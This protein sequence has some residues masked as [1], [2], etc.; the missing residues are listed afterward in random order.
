MAYGENSQ[1]SN[2]EFTQ[3]MAVIIGIN[4]YENGIPPLGTAQQDA[5]AIAEI[6]KQDYHYQTHSIINNQ[7][8]KQQLE[9]LLNIDLPNLIN[10]PSS[11]LIFY[12][13]GHGI[14]LNGDEGPQGYLIP[15]DGKLGDVSTYLPMQ[16][17]ETA[18][19]KL[20]CRHCFV[21]LD[22]CF[23]GAFRWSSTRR[24]IH[25]PKTIHKERYDRFIQDS[26]WQVIT[27]AGYDQT[28]LDNLDLKNDR[29]TA[30]NQVNHSP[31]A[32]ALMEALQGKADVYPPSQN[33][34][35]AGDGIITATELYLYLRDFVEVPTYALKQR[36]TPQIWSLSKHD[37][38]EF[39]FLVP[40]HPLNLPSAP[41]LDDI[42]ENNP[43]RGLKSYEKKHSNLFFGRTSLIKELYEFISHPQHPLTVVLGASGSGKSSLVKA[44]L[45][46][47]LDPLHQWKTLT[48]IRP[49]ETPL[50]RLNGLIKELDYNS[51]TLHQGITNWSKN[52][53]NQKL[54][55]VIDQLEELITL[56]RDEKEKEQFLQILAN[57]VTTYDDHL[58]IVVTLRSDFES[59][60]SS[61][62]LQEYWQE[63]RFIVPAMSRNDL[64][65]VIEEPASAKVVYFQSLEDK[66]YLVDRLIDEVAD[67]PG[68][69]PLLS[70][71][72]SE[73]Y[74]KLASRY[75]EGEKT[76]ET[77]DR[78]ITWQDYDELG[79]VI[80]SLTRRA[81]EEYNAL[82]KEDAAY[83]T[84]IR[85]VMLRMVAIGGEL[86]RRRVYQKELVYPE[87]EYGRV[88][89]FIKRF[90][91]VRL[92][93]SDQDERGEY[94]EPAHDALVTGWEKL[95]TWK[96][97]EEET[98]ILQRRLTPTAMEWDSQQKPVFLWH[99][100]P[101][102]DLLKKVANSDDNWL[103][104]VETEF[105]RRSV[106][107]KTFNTRRNWTVAITVML[108]LSAGLIFSLIGYRNTLIEG[109]IASQ[110]SAQANLRFNQSLDG[111]VDGLRAAK[112]IKHPLVQTPLLEQFNSTQTKRLQALQ[113]QITQTL[114]WAVYRVKET[115]RLTGHSSLIVRSIVS[116]HS[117]SSDEQFIASAGEDGHI[118]L[119]DFQGK[120]FKSWKGDEQRVWNVTFRPPDNQLLA[121]SGENGKI[122]I[123]SLQE[124]R[125][126]R[127]QY[128][129]EVPVYQ[130]ISAHQGYVRYVSFSPDGDQLAS[131]GGEDGQICLW[132]LHSLDKKVCWEVDKQFAK[133][134]DFHPNN[135]VMVTM[136]MDRTV[137][138]WDSQGES[139]KPLQIL[140]FV[141]WGA[142][143][144]PDGNYI[145]AAGNDG[146]IKVWPSQEGLVK[147][148]WKEGQKWLAHQGRI[149]NIAFSPNSQQIASGGE[150]GTVRVWDLKGEQ[151]A[152]FQGHNGPIRSVRFLADQYLISS[153][154]DGTTRVWNLKKPPYSDSSQ[155]T[156]RKFNEIIISSDREKLL[157]LNSADGIIQV[158]D[159]S[160]REPIEMI[161]QNT[162]LQVNDLIVSSN[163]KLVASAGAKQDNQINI[164]NQETGEKL[165]T[166]QDHVG[167][168]LKLDFSADSQR[169]VSAGEDNTI[170][171]WENL[172]KKDQGKYSLIFQIQ[173]EE[174]SDSQSKITS[175]KFSPD[176]QKII[177]GHNNGYIQF[178]DLE[179]NRQTAFWKAHLYPVKDIKFS[180]DGKTLYTQDHEGILAWEIET[181]DELVKKSC[182]QIGDFISKNPDNNISESYSSLCN[183][184]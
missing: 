61:T 74:L 122:R 168:V 101:R 33:G 66:G 51:K 10:T 57:L 177:T 24:F 102:L 47:Y 117:H 78:V 23:A 56:C 138:I 22:C 30:K 127:G 134:V 118:K 88:K 67:M 16:V 123:W 89:T 136:G 25:I 58:K 1:M 53:P 7:G 124:I 145:A 163:G 27:S 157:A 85:H 156:Q 99:T 29:G 107:R 106:D 147:P 54:L 26:A 175:V 129:D 28:A 115:N 96:K 82:I 38:G 50:T 63:G 166:F 180:S 45:I 20:S 39:I 174:T 46:P 69:L 171:V 71:A 143:F 97:E 81:D 35:P 152:E 130:E 49:G 83:A 73:L 19:S 113:N 4:N 94:V 160:Q 119:W 135:A 65:E 159:M 91:G 90:D 55:L 128:I 15:Q 158:G 155:N 151:L 42:E 148:E 98:L 167:Q 80:K 31:F 40:G 79:G 92:L 108:G 93:I 36:Q 109:A 103:N 154:D 125:N 126:F 181:F 153:G 169:L 75:L 48:P 37:K 183:I 182:Q 72:L 179:Q 131:V 178:W 62:A 43:Y 11:R 164:W 6:L 18:L 34:K 149:W 8:T 172:D 132:D 165:N 161:K 140:D 41:S 86:A 77:V 13:A 184:F 17:V 2:H 21:I 121:S 3:N 141:G 139:K 176:D 44:G 114:Q 87:P 76:G 60:F 173:E 162:A 84:T 120:L 14:A 52:H 170:R 32:K 12:F 104:L 144:S 112:A 133:T 59:Q 95:L 5:E 146:S 70:F 110:Q 150:D 100:N 111:M 142:F 137:K 105:V 116:H 64:R 9:Q 68:A